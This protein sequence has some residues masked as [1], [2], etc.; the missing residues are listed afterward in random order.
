MVVLDE[1]GLVTGH[2]DEDHRRV[3]I[4]KHVLNKGAVDVGVPVDTYNDDF[5]ACLCV[6]EATN[7][8]ILGKHVEEA[9]SFEFFVEFEFFVSG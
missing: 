3:Y 1:V 5:R 9:F 4:L 7:F 2:L 8:N 6:F